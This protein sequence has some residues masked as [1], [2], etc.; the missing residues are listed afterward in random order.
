MRPPRALLETIGRVVVVS[1]CGEH[2]VTQGVAR[3]VQGAAVEDAAVA[4]GARS[5]AFL[6]ALQIERAATPRAAAWSRASDGRV[7]VRRGPLGPPLSEPRPR[8][9]T[10][11]IC[12]AQDCLLAAGLDV[13]RFLAVCDSRTECRSHPRP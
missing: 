12:R 2:H 7:V 11:R 13:G 3:L 5:R 1:A 8:T 9:P 10:A 4:A 6:A